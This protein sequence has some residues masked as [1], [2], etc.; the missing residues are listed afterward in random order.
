MHLAD[1][2]SAQDCEGF[3]RARISR[4]GGGP[5][6]PERRAAWIWAHAKKNQHGWD[7]QRERERIPER[8]RADDRRAIAR[9]TIASD[10]PVA[11]A[12]HRSMRR[13]RAAGQRPTVEAPQFR[14]PRSPSRE[15]LQSASL[16]EFCAV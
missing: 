15:S 7:V 10:S 3:R 6:W 8:K 14:V 12:A 16:P 2:Q 4:R 11:V 5:M 13:K 9:R 1:R